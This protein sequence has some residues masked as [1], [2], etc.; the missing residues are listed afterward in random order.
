MA[1]VLP[2]SYDNGDARTYVDYPH[3]VDLGAFGLLIVLD[4]I[5]R[6]HLQIPFA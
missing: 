2:L 4:N 3:L 1:Y 5:K 6:V